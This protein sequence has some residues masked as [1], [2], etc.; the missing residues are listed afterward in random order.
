[1]D[2]VIDFQATD[3]WIKPNSKAPTNCG[4]LVVPEDWNV[5]NAQKI[6][7]PVVIYRAHNPDPSLSPV[8]FLSGGPGIAALGHKGEEI[9]EWRV[10]ADLLFPGRTL[11]IF[12]QRGTGLGSQR[13]D[14]HEHEVDDSFVWFPV[15]KNP[16][17]FGDLHSQ[18][19]AAS[20]ACAERHLAEGRQLHVFNTVQS[21]SDVEAL[22]RALNLK[23]I[24][25]FGLSYG[26]RLALT[27]MRLYPESI[28][29]A[30][31]DSV[32]PPQADWPGYDRKNF[33]IVL[34]RLFLACRQDES[35]AADHPDLREQ[36][37]RI[38][39]QLAKD[40]I[41]IEIT[42]LK[43]SEPLYVRIDHYMFLNVLQNEM[44]DTERL[45]WLPVLIADV[46][47]GEYQSLKYH[48]EN[49]VNGSGSNVGAFW[50]V[51]CNDD[52]NIFNRRPTREDA[53]SYPYLRHFLTPNREPSVCEAW[54]TKP[55]MGNPYVVTSAIP[56]LL[57]AG[58]FDPVT[59]VEYAEMAAETLS[60]SHLQVFPA[61]GHIQIRRNKCAWEL[62]NE[63]L[64]DPLER[65]NPECLSSLRQ[66][67][68][69]SVERK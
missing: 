5:P 29:A 55:D 34:D 50:A 37:L 68:F 43:G 41:I 21:A 42:N 40:P 45:Q 24:A 17:E 13:L 8:I 66:P 15:S 69:M 7:L 22:R 32:F 47:R 44:Y 62:I 18:V 51:M 61:N 23:K 11:I 59:T 35:C 30:I 63:F 31:L 39:D 6:K 58:G 25:L 20:A 19:F 33:G 56:T 54:R 3:C 64:S 26:T 52:A 14:C 9:S 65:P 57:L 49:T 27:V 1:M 53:E 2:D 67:A 16:G 28:N 36:F 10:S 12:D 38:V 60:M 48:V 46:A 4:W